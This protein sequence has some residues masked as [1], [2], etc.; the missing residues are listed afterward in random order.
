MEL[1]LLVPLLLVLLVVVVEVAAAARIQ[2]EVVAAAREGVRVAAVNPDPGQA[3][4]AAHRAL[5]NRGD[6][7]RIRVHRPHVVGRSAEVTVTLDRHINLPLL[8][9]LA[10]PLQARA[11]MRVER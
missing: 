8:G 7:A 4:A 9:R 10:V 1:A 2:I 3:V 11:V 5:G 6:E